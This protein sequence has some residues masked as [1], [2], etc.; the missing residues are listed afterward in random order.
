LRNDS[1]EQANSQGF[2]GAEDTA[3]KKKIARDFFAD[4]TVVR[5]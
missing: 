2:L 1:R 4:L 5:G 3:S